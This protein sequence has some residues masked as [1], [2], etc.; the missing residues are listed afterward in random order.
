MIGKLTVINGNEI[1]IEENNKCICRLY[2]RYKKEYLDLLEQQKLHKPVG[3][4]GAP[5]PPGIPGVP[6]PPNDYSGELHEDEKG[7]YYETETRVQY[8]TKEMVKLTCS[9]CSYSYSEFYTKKGVW[10]GTPMSSFKRIYRIHGEHF[11]SDC[12]G[13]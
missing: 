6:M 5:G 12:V 13:E 11:C 3:P 7:F 2:V 4:S 8:T 1:F 9:K 10:N